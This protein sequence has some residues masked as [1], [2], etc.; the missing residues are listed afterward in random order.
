MFSVSLIMNEGLSVGSQ[1]DYIRCARQEG[2]GVIV[3]NTN[4]NTDE[5]SMSNPHSP[6]RIRVS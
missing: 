1:F 3:T 5:F 2:Y 6:R 4:L